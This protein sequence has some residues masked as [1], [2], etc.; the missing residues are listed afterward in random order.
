MQ[1]LVSPH[2]HCQQQAH[3]PNR[4]SD[5]PS[6]LQPIR[7]SL[8]SVVCLSNHGD[9]KMEG[10]DMWR[11]TEN[12]FVSM[13]VIG[14]C[15][16][17]KCMITLWIFKLALW[18]FKLASRLHKVLVWVVSKVWMKEVC[19]MNEYFDRQDGFNLEI[20]FGWKRNIIDD[21]HIW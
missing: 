9:T 4:S 1:H 19:C 17:D 10:N 2:K 7:R 18:I 15:A 8:L 20:E 12:K 3:G 13:A 14:Y 16:C 5:W 21:Q 6:L 11:A